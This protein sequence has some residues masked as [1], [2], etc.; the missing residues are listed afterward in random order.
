MTSVAQARS[1]ERTDARR[2]S[3]SVWIRVN[4][5]KVTLPIVVVSTSVSTS[6]MR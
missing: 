2:R 5:G 6:R 1:P 3:G 4:N